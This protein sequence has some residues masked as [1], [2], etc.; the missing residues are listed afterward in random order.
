MS[1]IRLQN[2]KGRITATVRQSTQT[3]AVRT[4]DSKDEALLWALKV[5]NNINSGKLNLDFAG[6]EVY[7]HD[8]FSDYLEMTQKYR[9]SK[10]SIKLYEQALKHMK[11]FFGSVSV[12]KICHNDYQNVIN[13]LGEKWGNAYLNRF[14]GYVKKAIEYAEGENFQ[15]KDFTTGTVFLSKKKPKAEK[16][17]YLSDE[18]E[19]RT[20]Y[21]YLKKH[22]DDKE[23]DFLNYLLYF[24]RYGLRP[25][26]LYG[27]KWNHLFINE[28]GF[29]Y[30]WTSSYDLENH[31]ESLRNKTEL[32]DQIPIP[33]TV[34]DYQLLQVLK[35]KQEKAYALFP[36]QR[37]NE[38]QLIFASPKYKYG[39]PTSTETINRRL[40]EC[41]G[42]LGL[43]TN[44][45]LYAMRHTTESIL[46]SKVPD[47]A[48]AYKAVAEQWGHSEITF[49]NVYFHTLNHDRKMIEKIMREDLREDF[50]EQN[51][52]KV[53]KV[54]AGGLD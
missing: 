31:Q 9:N 54:S 43:N 23:N 41:L 4:F 35:S 52:N 12:Y 18:K 3:V 6:K 11:T 53:G 48:S 42:A 36:K 38:N 21:S 27:M 46:A 37:K 44:L 40:R 7:L 32:R 16:N 34:E 14:N 29:P 2:R 8:F 24:S 47:T 5:K 33:L 51:G 13:Y 39:L 1:S 26:E 49:K 17:K 30:F 28:K 22:L 10:G 15:L 45:T 25:R 50:W 20:L 19:C